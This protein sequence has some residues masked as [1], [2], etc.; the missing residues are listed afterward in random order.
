MAEL[1]TDDGRMR[2]AKEL[3][4]RF[5]QLGI[6]EVTVVGTYCGS[7]VTAAHTALALHEAGVEADVYVGSWSDW[8]TDSTRP[9]AT[10]A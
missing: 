9:I 10:G 4:A 2:P 3:R 5:A 8:I 6:D 1:V 7:G